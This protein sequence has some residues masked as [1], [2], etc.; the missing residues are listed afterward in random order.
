MTTIP[1]TA[2]WSSALPWHTQMEISFIYMNHPH[3]SLTMAPGAPLG[4]F[5]PRLPSSPRLPSRP[6]RPRGP[7]GPGA[8]WLPV[9]PC[10]P[11]APSMPL[12]PLMPVGPRMPRGPVGPLAPCVA[13][14]RGS[15]Q[16]VVQ[17]LIFFNGLVR[18]CIQV[19]AID[20]Y[21]CHTV[22]QWPL[23]M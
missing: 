19:Y 13:V 18:N 5:L 2:E 10:N 21:E 1:D 20:K 3:W 15:D 4:P 7:G 11:W 23:E 9:S 16:W 6:R 8:P 14:S 12:T 22:H 17:M